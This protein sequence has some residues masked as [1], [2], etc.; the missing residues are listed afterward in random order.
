M[1]YEYKP[2][3][4]LKELAD[5]PAPGE[6]KVFA[7]G[8]PMLDAHGI[9]LQKGKFATMV[10]PYGSGKSI[11]ARQLAC[12]MARLHGWQTLLTAFE[13]KVKW[14]MVR[15]LRWNF[16]VF[17]D[18]GELFS[19]AGDPSEVEQVLLDKRIHE[20]F[21]F[22]V[23]PPSILMDQMQLLNSIRFA[24]EKYNLDMV[25]VD[26]VNE[27]DHHIPRGM[28]RTDYMGDFI[29][30]LKAIA[31]DHDVLVM[32]CV[33][34]PKADNANRRK[35]FFTLNDAADSAHYGN[36]SDFGW[37]AWRPHWDAPTF[38]NIDK[39]KDH[40]LCGKPDLFEMEL[41]GERIF[42]PVSSGRNALERWEQEAS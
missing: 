16:H 2:I 31:H 35:H 27:I 18:R 33:H 32:V 12:N 17:G 21:K 3:D 42:V 9:R 26:P 28:S 25:I 6:E 41:R 37:A 22:L 23:R 30:S 15:Q 7:T 39:I 19:S 13:E 40:E 36:K 38:L 1:N 4:F 5:I 11:L 14:R 24:A 8:F 10:G 20:H 29:M 34:P